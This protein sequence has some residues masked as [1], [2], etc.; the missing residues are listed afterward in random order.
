MKWPERNVFIPGWGPDPQFSCTLQE[1]CY[2]LKTTES[3][4]E[5]KN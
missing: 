3:V 2:T 1:I 5:A 4:V